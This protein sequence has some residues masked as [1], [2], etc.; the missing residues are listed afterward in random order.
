MT[1]LWNRGVT[2]PVSCQGKSVFRM[3]QSLGKGVCSSRA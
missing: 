3:M 2:K 1:K